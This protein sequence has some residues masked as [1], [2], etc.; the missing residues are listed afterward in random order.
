MYFIQKHENKNLI[1]NER[2]GSQNSQIIKEDSEVFGENKFVFYNRQICRPAHWI[3][4]KYLF[5]HSR[6]IAN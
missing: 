2:K 3:P 1:N 5:S 6:L 4:V